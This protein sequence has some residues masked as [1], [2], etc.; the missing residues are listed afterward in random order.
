MRLTL[1]TPGPTAGTRAS[2][3]GDTA[4]LVA[5]PA[6]LP[7]RR[8]RFCGPEPACLE[9]AGVAGVA[10]TVL[11]ALAG[12]DFGAWTGLGLEQVLGQDAP[13]LAQWLAD[14][15][16]RPHGGESLAQHLERIGALLDAQPWP[17]A[18]AVVVASPF[19]VRAALVHAMAAGSGSLLHLDVPPGTVATISRHAG[20][21]RCQSLV[22][23][24][25]AAD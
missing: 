18:G 24:K 25:A 7:G 6:P 11:P 22:P 8:S 17:E 4:S 16:A 12:P 20:R 2:V 19:T 13:G 3:F 14:P 15:I 5:A 23:P 1:V 9:T 10:S 21:W